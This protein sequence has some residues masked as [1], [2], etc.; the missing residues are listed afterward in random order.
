MNQLLQGI[1]YYLFHYVFK[2]FGLYTLFYIL[3]ILFKRN[4]KSVKKYDAIACK[5]MGTIGIVMGILVTVNT[6]LW[7]YQEATLEQQQHYLQRLTGSYGYGIW[8]NPLLLLVL[9]QLLWIPFLRK[10][11]LYRLLTLPFFLFTIEQIIILTTSFHRDYLP[12]SYHTAIP[13]LEIIIALI[14]FLL[15]T[16]GIYYFLK[17]KGKISGE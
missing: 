6:L 7:Y 2:S 3:W 12:S 11:L 15:V 13:I 17:K 4:N 1:E 14:G 16:G 8:F 9:S 10:A 5:L